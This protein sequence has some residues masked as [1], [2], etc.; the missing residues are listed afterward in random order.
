MSIA[1]APRR[2]ITR[3]RRALRSSLSSLA[4][5]LAVQT[6]RTAV[7]AATTAAMRSRLTVRIGFEV[8]IIVRSVPQGYHR[9]RRRYHD[10]DDA[11]RVHA[12]GGGA[13]E[14]HAAR[15]RL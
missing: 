12:A 1:S 4:R 8:R 15:A 9:A 2:S 3:A 14:Q 5:A 6:A 7:A 10:P 11:A 13:R